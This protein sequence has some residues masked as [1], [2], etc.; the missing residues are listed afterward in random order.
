MKSKERLLKAYAREKSD[1]VP[2]H[3]WGVWPLPAHQSHKRGPSFAPLVE[4]IKEKCDPVFRFEHDQGFLLSDVGGFSFDNGKVIHENDEGYIRDCVIDTPKGPLSYH[5]QY[6]HNKPASTKKYWIDSEEDIEKVFSFPYKKIPI[7][8]GEFFEWE[9]K[10]GE[11]G[12]AGVEVSCPAHYIHALLGSEKLAL[13]SVTNRNLIKKLFAMMA[14]SVYDYVERLLDAGLGPVFFFDSEEY[15]T[16]PLHGPNDFQEF[17]VDLEKPIIELIHSRGCIARIHCHGNIGTLLD[18]F[19]DLGVDAL[20]PVEEPPMGDVT[21]E[22]FREKVGDRIAIEGNI[23]ISDIYTLT[24]DEID[25]QVK[26]VI[27]VAGK[28][29]GLVLAPSASPLSSILEEKVLNN[30]KAFIDAGLKYGQY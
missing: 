20:H 10:L 27:E 2:I 3:I 28:D 18:K 16:P 1:R 11:D 30:Y 4:Q 21:L 9:N 24:P 19:L 8:A 14:D 6:F 7:N 25:Q 13:W 17:V 5:R 26:H 29:G 23:Q 22:E 15:I 12:L